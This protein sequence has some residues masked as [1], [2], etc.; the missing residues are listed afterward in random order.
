MSRIHGYSEAKKPATLQGRGLAWNTAITRC[1][2]AIKALLQLHSISL[3]GGLLLGQA[4]NV[5]APQ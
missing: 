4:V 1:S 5:A 3:R 2:L